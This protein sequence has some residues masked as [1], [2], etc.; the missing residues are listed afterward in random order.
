ML[1]GIANKAEAIDAAAVDRGVAVP[2]G[3]PLA[4]NGAVPRTT[5]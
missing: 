1:V 4:V 2:G 3:N 5:A